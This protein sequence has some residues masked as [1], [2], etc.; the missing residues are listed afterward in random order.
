MLIELQQ[1]LA[2]IPGNKNSIRVYLESHKQMFLIQLRYKFIYLNLFEVVTHHPEIKT[3][4]LKNIAYER[5][6]AK[7]LFGLYV[8]SGIIKKGIHGSQ[9][10]KIVN[11]GQIIN[12]AWLID[13][14]IA[15]KGDKKKQLSYYMGICCGLLEPY[16]TVAAAKEYRNYF[17]GL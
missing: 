7:K 13:A 12:A 10:E 8:K 14:E 4:Y 3:I 6:I 2:T 15:Y 9:F 5:K 11:V 16:L 17:A 1:V